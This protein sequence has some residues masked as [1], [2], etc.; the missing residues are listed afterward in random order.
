MVLLFW[1]AVTGPIARADISITASGDWTRTIDAN[2]LQSGAGSDLTSTYESATDQ[3]TIDISG[4]LGDLDNWRVDVARIDFAWHSDLHQYIKRTSDGT[5]GGS[6]S[7]GTSY[8]EVINTWQTFF[9]GS[10]DRSNIAVQLKL[11]G[12]S[13]QIP[14]NNYSAMIFF[15]V[16]DTS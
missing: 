10:G 6:I 7:G 5:G 9:S 16:I 3:V 11:T 15:M 2:D 13:I 8:Q 14:V 4:T 12:V 1:L